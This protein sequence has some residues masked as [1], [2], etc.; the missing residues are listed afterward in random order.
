MG[1]LLS[2]DWHLTDNPRDEYRWGIF[3]Y[4]KEL[5]IKRKGY[6]PVGP[7][8]DYLII[9]GDITDSKDRHRSQLV[10]RLIE[11]FVDLSEWVPDIIILAGNHDSQFPNTPFFNF[12][13]HVNGRGP[14]LITYISEP[15]RLPKPLSDVAVFPYDKA[16]AWNWRQHDCS[17]TSMILAHATFDGCVVENDQ[18]MEGLPITCFKNRP[19]NTPIYAGDIHVPQKIGPLEY[20]G[21][22][23]PIRFGD[24]YTPRLM[25]LEESPLIGYD[26][27]YPTIQ[28]HMLTIS[29]PDELLAG[30]LNLKENDQI[31]V[32][33]KLSRAE[34]N[35]WD[36]LKRQVTDICKRKNL[37]LC[38]VEFVPSEDQKQKVTRGVTRGVFSGASSNKTTI[39]RFIGDRGIDEYT[40]NVG[41]KLMENDN[42]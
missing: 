12:L 2:A 19:E 27:Y 15:T 22:P 7:S 17:D 29:S 37:V 24:T 1:I 13:N 9:L 26:Y 18:V 25:Y 39:E 6:P 31:K 28:K 36:S 35:E 4:I 34:R 40:A 3:D 33:L 8:I 20:I 30:G 38:G 16:A 21:A 5:A 41:K 14:G 32:R 10:N 42:V 23:Y 11:N